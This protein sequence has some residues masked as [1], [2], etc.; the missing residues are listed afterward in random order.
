MAQHVLHVRLVRKNGSF[1][2]WLGTGLLVA[3]APFVARAQL[4]ESG[5]L[6]DPFDTGSSTEVDS[7]TTP[8]I[9]SGLSDTGGLP[10][11]L[12]GPTLPNGEPIPPQDLVLDTSKGCTCTAI[13]TSAGTMLAPAP[14]LLA[15]ALLYRRRT[16]TGPR[17]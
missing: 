15:A 14:I 8:I 12:P 7:A 3:T 5:V 11:T 2:A 1:I 13:A 10:D 17:K 6:P 9:D 16:K 4:E